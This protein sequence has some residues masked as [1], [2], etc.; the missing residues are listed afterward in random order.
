MTL[1]LKEIAEFI[2]TLFADG[3]NTDQVF[4]ICAEKYPALTMGDLKTALQIALHDSGAT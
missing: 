2:G 1:R 3:K 4:E